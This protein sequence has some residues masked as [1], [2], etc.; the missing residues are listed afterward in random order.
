MQ[1]S[2]NP[3]EYPSV[4]CDK[5]NCETFIPA[6][7]FK[8]VPGVVAGSGTEDSL[9]PIPVYICSK[10]GE[11]MPDYRKMIPTSKNENTDG[12]TPEGKTIQT[13]LLS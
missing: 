8:R 4:V 2:V 10:C 6:A 1:L 12:S 9:V 5:C 3:L 11:L 7:V 13:I